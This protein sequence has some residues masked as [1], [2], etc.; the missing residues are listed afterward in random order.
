MK[1]SASKPALRIHLRANHR[2]ANILQSTAIC[3]S[4]RTQILE[5]AKLIAGFPPR[6]STISDGE[7]KKAKN[8]TDY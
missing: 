7:L 4:M 3:G 8:V 1:I 2:F 5:N 6:N